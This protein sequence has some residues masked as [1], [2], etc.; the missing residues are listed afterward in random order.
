M[1]QQIT[2]DVLTIGYLSGGPEGGLPV[3]LLH[4]WPDDPSGWAGV[5]SAIEHAGFRWAAPWLRGFGP[6]RFLSADAVRDGTTVAIAQDALELADALGWERFAV[7][8]HDWG[9]RA[10]YVL[11]ALAPQRVVS[12]A[13]LAIGYSPGGRIALPASF[14]QSRRWWYQ[15][16]MTTTGGAGAVKS[17]PVGFARIQWETW[18][19]T[20]WFEEAAFERV[21]ESFRNPDWAAI[22]LHGYRSRWQSEPLDPRY[23]AQRTTVADTEHLGVPALM[24]Q[25]CADACDPP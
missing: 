19:P 3:L 5:T 6:T 12:I 10:A 13:A 15:W 1:T 8:G 20:G 24:V 25:G 9:G 2:T 22:T 14:A 23:Q 11:A 17:D 4:G 21:A 18:S 16:F 7:I